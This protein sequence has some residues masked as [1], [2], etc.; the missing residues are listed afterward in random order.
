M[1]LVRVTTSVLASCMCT[2]ADKFLFIGSRLGDSLLVTYR[3]KIVVVKP[4]ETTTSASQNEEDEEENEIEMELEEPS[5]KRPRLEDGPAA[6]GRVERDLDSTDDFLSALDE[7]SGATN[8]GNGDVS[9]EKQQAPKAENYEAEMAAIYG[10]QATPTEMQ[11]ETIVSYNLKLCETMINIGPIACMTIS[12]DIRHHKKSAMQILGSS[13]YGRNGSIC[14]LNRTIRPELILENELPFKVH[15]MWTMHLVD[16]EA[17]D[18]HRT[19]MINDTAHDS[20][21]EEDDEDEDDHIRSYLVF[22]LEK[23]T[24]ILEYI[25]DLNEITDNEGVGIYKTDTTINMGTL[26]KHTRGV[27]VCTERVILFDANAALLEEID[28]AQLG[29]TIHSSQICDPFILLHFTDGSMLLLE[30]TG[31]VSAGSVSVFKTKR[32]FQLTNGL[33]KI[34]ATALFSGADHQLSVVSKKNNEMRHNFCILC[35]SSGAMEIY[36]VPEFKCVFSFLP[37]D[38]LHQIVSDTNPSKDQIKNFRRTSTRIFVKEIMMRSIGGARESPH[39]LVMLNDD[40]LHVYKSFTYSVQQ[41]QGKSENETKMKDASSAMGRERL[42]ALRFVKVDPNIMQRRIS[43][44]ESADADVDRLQLDDEKNIFA[45]SQGSTFRTKLVPF[46]DI[47]RLR[48]VFLCGKNPTWI[49]SDRGKLRAHPMPHD[50]PIPSFAPFANVGNGFVY[51]NERASK[52]KVC[53]LRESPL[54]FYTTPWPVQ[55]VLMKATP[56]KIICHDS[57]QTR[58]VATSTSV[59]SELYEDVEYPPEEGGRYPLLYEDAYELR[60]YNAR[61]KQIDKFE[62]E[63]REQ[64]LSLAS[65]MISKEEIHDDD[66]EYIVDV[67]DED[68]DTAKKC[69]LL[70]AVGT[71]FDEGED[72]AGRGKIYLFDYE[73]EISEDSNQEVLKLTELANKEVKGP[74][75]ALQQLNGYLICAVGPKL[76]VYYY[77]WDSKQLVAS[78]FLDTQFATVSLNT[79]K[80]YILYGDYWRG[81]HFLR[82]RERGHKLIEL[83]RDSNPMLRVLRTEYMVDGDTLEMMVAD[84]RKNIQ[85]FTYQPHN[86]SSFA[87]KK[88][89]PVADFHTGQ[90]IATTARLKMRPVAQSGLNPLHLTLGGTMKQQQQQQNQWQRQQQ[91]QNVFALFGTLEGSIGYVAP[92]DEQTYRRLNLLSI[93]MYTQLPHAA[94]LHPK[95]YRQYDPELVIPHT[96]MKNVIDGQ[97]VWWYGNL[98]QDTQRELA[99]QV[100]TNPERVFMNIAHLN[101]ATLFY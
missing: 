92:I 71:G 8:F 99:K 88:L 70:I 96:H 38:A 44:D 94:G 46:N 65:C 6:L 37:F 28:M 84:V 69:E 45:T 79:F 36:S 60:V 40:S 55:R 16:E 86:V 35:W 15:Q 26:A 47:S 17:R 61:W 75:T 42:D 77:D 87:G 29:K 100:G 20:D 85:I 48:G 41:Q 23:N 30:Y 18:R 1:D 63:S 53:Q 34:T 33:G 56:H 64:V 39:L 10:T 83:S 62:F 73:A 98:D 4:A 58:V 80:N 12:E 19:K 93:K 3:E 14:V 81:A 54:T 76:Y 11:E 95:R 52:F 31:K 50:A 25:D 27:Q 43:E 24:K 68:D 22:A 89:M 72:E 13:G 2:I 67:R 7:V 32:K 51:F 91:N 21:E 57:T 74:V 49:L 66:D 101:E 82:W 78:S 97:L 9:K 90:H 5:A 59:L